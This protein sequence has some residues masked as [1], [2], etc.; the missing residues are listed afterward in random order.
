MNRIP[1]EFVDGL[2]LEGK[3]FETFAHL[4]HADELLENFL[5]FLLAVD[6]TAAGF[7]QNLGRHLV[8]G[9]KVDRHLR[10][11]SDSSLCCPP[12]PAGPKPTFFFYMS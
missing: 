9:E 6:V 3:G 5:V 8:I 7:G 10:T 4:K 12:H 1:V 2:E 11:L